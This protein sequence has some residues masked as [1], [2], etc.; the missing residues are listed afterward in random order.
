MLA[1]LNIDDLK[2]VVVFRS[3]RMD[4]LAVNAISKALD[5]SILRDRSNPQVMVVAQEEV[6]EDQIHERFNNAQIIRIG[7]GPFKLTSLTPLLIWRLRKFDADAFIIPFNTPDRTGYALIETL[8]LLSGAGD[9]IGVNDRTEITRA[10]SSDYLPAKT[11]T[12]MVN[13]LMEKALPFMHRRPGVFAKIFPGYLYPKRML[14]CLTQK[15]NLRCSFCTKDHYWGEG[16]D[17]D[18]ENLKI[19]KNPLTHASTIDISGYAEVFIY[20][21]LDEVLDY[22]YSL[23]PRQELIQVTTNGS[24]LSA[25]WARRLRGR[26]KTMVISLNSAD[27]VTYREWMK[28]DFHKTEARIR[29][30]VNELGAEESGKLQLH[31]VTHRDNLGEME[32]FVKLAADIGIYTV[33]FHHLQVFFKEHIELSLL[34]VKEEYNEAVKRAQKVGK[35]LGV[36][37]LARTFFSE[38]PQNFDKENC[39]SPFNETHI[40]IDGEMTICCYAGSYV[41]GFVYN[42]GFENLWFGEAYRKL[43]R[44]RYLDACKVCVP[45]LPFD[46]HLIHFHTLIK[47]TDEFKEMEKRLE[48]VQYKK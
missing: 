41:V 34:N 1:D 25:K 44:S 47:E 37:V 10:G 21:R 19:L 6:P 8:G 42:E 15:C 28:Y 4:G 30:F 9:V 33:S 45:Y 27:P 11:A 31:F 13:S 32:D 40:A 17:F 5:R 38:K 14:L 26:L 23:N 46:D 2:R 35:E 20:S 18:F 3:A 36:T 48:A 29:E 43:R 16:K 24:A 22:I 7:N 12:L 39:S